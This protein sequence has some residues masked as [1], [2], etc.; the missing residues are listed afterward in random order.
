MP[1]VAE[2]WAIIGG[3]ILGMTLAH[4]LAQQGKR[5]TLFEGASHLG[6]LASAWTLDDVVWD[7]HYHVTLLSDLR[8]R[9]LLTE[10]GLEQE[11]VWVETKTGVYADGKLYSV[12]NALEF[13]QFPPLGLLDKLRLGLTIIYGSK[14]KNWRRLEKISVA[15]W[16]QRWSGKRTFQKFWLPLL[17]AKLGE[18]YKKASASFIWST[19]A[20]L[21]AA[22]RTGLKKELFG[23]LPGGYARILERFAAV[24]QQEGV[25]IRLNHTAR[26]IESTRSDRITI[27]F[28]NHHQA[29]FDQV[30]ITTAAPIAAQIC[31]GLSQNEI[32]RLKQ[33]QYQGIICA[34]LLL[35]QPLS[36]YYVTNI[37]DTWVP[38]TGVI[39]M[40]TL[41][42]R[43]EF[44]GRTL[45]YLP[46]Y[47]APDDP[48]FALSDQELETILVQALERLYPHF[49]RSDV[50]SF[51]VSRVKYVLAIATLNYSEHLPPMHTSIPGVHII[52]S[53]H[54]LNGTLNVNETIQLA[55]TA[56]QSLD[57]TMPKPSITNVSHLNARL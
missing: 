17:R 47:I 33:I 54:I 1:E 50:L 45:V 18:N 25:E 49:H 41:V 10:L 39:E 46:K 44:G 55:E 28:S 56:A 36:P 30:V 13:L 19:I 12:S 22:R 24:L 32:D 2:Q 6:G 51:Q 48:A 53:A 42:D 23:Y 37:T 40:T 43:K 31:A 7:R 34:S 14:I 52:N 16:L 27:E 15:D 5:V 3:G 8:F 38:F 11:M 35:K 9:S 20:R 21:Y 29:T 57:R 4:R 26:Q